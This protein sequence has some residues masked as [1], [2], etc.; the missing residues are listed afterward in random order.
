MPVVALKPRPK[1]T[2]GDMLAATATKK[3]PKA[4]KS[5]MPTLQA[6]PEVAAAVD[7]YQESKVNYKQAEAAMGAAAQII[8]DFVGKH[9]DEDGYAGHYQGSYAVLGVKE[10]DQGTKKHQA[11]VIYANK[12][13]INPEDEAE[14]AEIL[15]EHFEGMINKQFSVKL[16]AEVLEDE[17]LQAELLDLIGDRFRDFFETTTSLSVADGFSRE[18]YRAV[19]SEQMDAL[20]TYARQYKPSL[21]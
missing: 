1:A 7:Q 19:P 20:R 5:S 13:S 3:E 15:G 6:T 4:K 9:Q 11:K 17:A 2:F 8:M 21:R 16:R 10:T 12:F 14:L 18:I